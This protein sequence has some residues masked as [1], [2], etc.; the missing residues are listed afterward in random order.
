MAVRDFEGTEIGSWS[1]S[2]P[3][4]IPCCALTDVNVLGLAQRLG[5]QKMVGHGRRLRRRGYCVWLQ[6]RGPGGHR[7]AD[8]R[9]P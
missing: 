6:L 5:E 8:A 9:S 7:G 3:P 4:V 2:G 1:R